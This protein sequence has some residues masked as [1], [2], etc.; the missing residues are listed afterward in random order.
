MCTVPGMLA[1]AGLNKALS[2][3]KK[4][5]QEPAAPAPEAPPVARMGNGY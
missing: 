1:G 4:P 3:K 5:K 2:K